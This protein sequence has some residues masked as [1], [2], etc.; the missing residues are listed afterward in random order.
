MRQ[1]II[2]AATGAVLAA[3]VSVLVIVATLSARG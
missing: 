2:G 1:Y 3:L